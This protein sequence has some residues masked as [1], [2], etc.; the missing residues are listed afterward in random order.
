MQTTLE[1]LAPPKNQMARLLYDMIN[2]RM[3][4]EQDYHFNR[5]RGSLSD[6]RNDYGVPI[7]H[8]DE[9]FTN[10]FGRESRYRRHYI[11]SVDKE[12]AIEVYHKL[13]NQ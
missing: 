3:I 1:F 5:F 2:G 4:S 12:Q 7:R 9:K 10:S 13:N 11:L 8:Q 6:L